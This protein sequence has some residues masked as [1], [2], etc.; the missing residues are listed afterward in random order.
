MAIFTSFDAFISSTNG[1][2]IGA[3]ECW[4]YAQLVW[5]YLGGRLWTYPP[6]NPGA[7]NHGVKW[8]VLN[9]EAR[10]AST[11]NHL[12]F[13]SNKNELQ[14]G[15]I[16]V[17][18]GGAYGH[19]GFINEDYKS[20]KSSFSFYSQNYNGKRYVTLGTYSLSDF[21]GAWRYD[22]WND[23]PPTPPPTPPSQK[24]KKRFPFFIYNN[25]LRSK[26]KL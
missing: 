11:I 26:Y 9:S 16:V 13:I 18:T 12:T 24:K 5:S 6:S 1:R 7:T 25:R 2:T 23:T 22:A 15:D 14:R 4:D 20:S 10:N 17:T 8:S 21:G 3:G 19:V